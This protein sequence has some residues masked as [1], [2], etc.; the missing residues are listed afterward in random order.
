M[1]QFHANIDISEWKP[2]AIATIFFVFYMHTL[3][4]PSTS[5]C[6][7]FPYQ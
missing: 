5:I 2:K 4:T 1:L 7:Q 3:S 6:N